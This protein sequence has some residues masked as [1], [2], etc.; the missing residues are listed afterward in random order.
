MLQDLSG[1][2]NPSLKTHALMITLAV[3]ENAKTF[4]NQKL[5]LKKCIA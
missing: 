1:L 3:P 4:E 5:H 2:A